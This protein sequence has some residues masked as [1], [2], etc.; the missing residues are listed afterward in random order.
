MQMKRDPVGSAVESKGVSPVSGESERK[1]PV[2][3]AKAAT[4]PDPEVAE[5]PVRRKF[6]AGYKLHILDLADEC[7]ESGSLGKLLRKEGLYSSTLSDWRRQREQGILRGLSPTK[8]GPKAPE[9]NP[10]LPEVEGLRK[11]NKRLMKRLNKAEL[12][13][14]VQKKISQLLGLEMIEGDN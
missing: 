5:K 1:E 13:L 8:R 2:A 10:L 6:S 3:E 11:E 9:P 7:T 12:L 4:R 14:D